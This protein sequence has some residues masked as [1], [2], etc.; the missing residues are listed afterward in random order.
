[1]EN[2][3]IICHDIEG[4]EY[5]IDSSQLTWRPSAYGVLVKDYKV[6]L[7]KQWDGYDF[8]GGGINMDEKVEEA[9]VREFWEET[10]V[11]VDVGDIVH[12]A[13]SFFK[14]PFGKKNEY[15][16]SVLIFYICYQKG[17]KLSTENFDKDEKEYADM[18][19]WVSINEVD[20]IKFMNPVDSVNLI[21]KVSKLIK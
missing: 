2:K 8:P 1:M 9:V 13:D 12:V 6:L 7:S 19:E 5:T 14:P 10:G 18:P 3:K 17:G 16:H 15:W 20:K 11:K 4:K 21:K